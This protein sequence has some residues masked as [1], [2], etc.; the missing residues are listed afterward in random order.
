MDDYKRLA[1]LLDDLA[2]AIEAN[3]PPII[4]VDIN[5]SAV[6]GASATGL[7]VIA[8]GGGGGSTGL[9]VRVAATRPGQSAYGVKITV[10]GPVATAPALPRSNEE[11]DA[12][13]VEIREASAAA[14]AG[15]PP[16]A[17]VR[18]MVQVVAGWGKVGIAAAIQ[19]A[20]AKLA[21][22]GFGYGG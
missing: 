20:V 17:A 11:I 15:A 5:V 9:D 7:A 21:E 14:R 2:K 6:P 19:G 12:V 18:R 3:P 4:G 10:G 16:V 1:D 8:A 13:I 22:L